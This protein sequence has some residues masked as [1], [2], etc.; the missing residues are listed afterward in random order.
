MRE[1]VLQ[2]RCNYCNTKAGVMDWQ[3]AAA[4]L[5]GRQ[6]EHVFE[7][8][9]HIHMQASEDEMSLPVSACR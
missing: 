1:R 6:R 3:H 5:R 8:I 9:A 2:E 4:S 7:E